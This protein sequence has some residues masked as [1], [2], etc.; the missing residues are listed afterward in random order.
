MTPP[1]REPRP[2][3]RGQALGEHRRSGAV[4]TL[5]RQVAQRGVLPNLFLIGAPRCGTTFL[6]D[7]L[8]QHPRIFM[9]PVKEP[10]YF[11]APAGTVWHGPGDAQPVSSLDRY[12]RVFSAAR[13]D[14]H[15]F[16][17][18]ASTLYLSAETAPARIRDISP[19]AR[20]MCILRNPVDRA[21]SHFVQHRSQAREVCSRLVDAVACEGERLREGW[22]PFWGYTAL[23]RY[24]TQLER[25]AEHFPASQFRVFLYDDLAHDTAAFLD[26]VT[27]FLGLDPVPH[28]VVRLGTRNEARL[29]RNLVA[30][31]FLSETRGPLS[32][33]VRA[34][35]PERSRAHL[36]WL[37]QRWNG[38]PA[39]NELTPGERLTLAATFDADVE[40]VERLTDRDLAAWRM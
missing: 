13:P 38:R 10:L 8:R 23:S 37:L 22:A 5:A 16:V 17:G 30:A 27:A 1:V 28:P 3:T 11:A 14:T 15:L 18:E 12:L 2:G 21:W 20:V 9:S 33:V 39:F 4:S 40:C 35:V 31:R 32:N 36:R 34:L 24:G 25:W 19:G 6:W 7:Y 26:S 29:P